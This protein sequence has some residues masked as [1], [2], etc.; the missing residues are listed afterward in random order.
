MIYI[1]I[2]VFVNTASPHLPTTAGNISL[3]HSWVQ[4]FV[5]V[6]LWPLSFWQPTFTVGKW[7]P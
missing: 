6:F 4:Y 3:F 1:V 5:S 2:G 7:H